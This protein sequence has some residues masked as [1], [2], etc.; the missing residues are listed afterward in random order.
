MTEVLF[1]HLE[2]ARLDAVLPD[3]LEKTLAKGWKALVRTREASEVKALD[4]MLWTWRDDSF[5]P[6]GA[7]DPEDASAARQPIWLTDGDDHPNAGNIVFFVNGARAPVEA[8]A[9]FD[10]VVT[11]FNG[12]NDND[13]ADARDF[14]KAVKAAGLDAT[15]WKQ[16]DGGRWE[17]QG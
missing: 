14:W 17:K 1:Y 7:G 8:L 12:R 10:R 2:R 4:E 13:V 16:S 5:L 15:Y 11:I 3:L 6:H 9:G